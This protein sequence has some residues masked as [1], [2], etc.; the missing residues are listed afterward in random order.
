MRAFIAAAAVLIAIGPAQAALST[1]LQ[2]NGVQQK[3]AMRVVMFAVE[4]MT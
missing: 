3:P 2:N 1:K 4:G